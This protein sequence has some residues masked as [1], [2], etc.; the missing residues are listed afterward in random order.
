MKKKSVGGQLRGVGTRVWKKE[1]YYLEGRIIN[2]S[3]KRRGWYG[4]KG[5]G[6]ELREERGGYIRESEGRIRVW[7]GKRKEKT[8]EDRIRVEER[9]EWSKWMLKGNYGLKIK[10]MLVGRHYRMK[11]RFKW[12]RPLKQIKCQFGIGNRRHY[13]VPLWG[14]TRIKKIRKR[15]Y[16]LYTELK[17]NERRREWLS[18]LYEELRRK[19]PCNLYTGKGFKFA[20]T[21][22]W[23]KVSKKEGVEY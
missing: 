8:K 22:V 18:Y 11:W 10:L 17:F 12:K 16:R 13:G 21:L 6:R 9:K 5:L 23:T 20:K 15:Y 14:K 2:V 19:K 4:D 1:M 3:N 7:Y